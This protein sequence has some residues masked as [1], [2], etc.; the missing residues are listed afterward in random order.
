MRFTCIFSSD[1]DDLLWTIN[2]NTTT[3][4]E[5]TVLEEQG[6][7]YSDSL[8]LPVISIEPRA[9][10]DNIT[11]VCIAISLG[12]NPSIRNSIEVVFRVQGKLDLSLIHCYYIVCISGLLN[13]PTGLK[14]EYFNS[15]HDNLTWTDPYILNLTDTVNYITGYT[16]TIIMQTLP[17]HY[18]YNLSLNLDQLTT[19]IINQTWYIS[20]HTPYFSFPRYTF[21]QWMSV[22]AENPAGQGAESQIF[23]YTC[24]ITNDCWRLSGEW[25]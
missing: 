25:D 3:E 11:I 1:T 21:S 7:T 13:P 24:N 15:T 6:I 4:I 9:V 22:S 12:S 2:G 19:T 14:T 10:N 23:N 17:L 8:T 18:S 5:E 16:I 20:G